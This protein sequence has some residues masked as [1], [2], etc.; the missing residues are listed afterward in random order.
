MA[1]TFLNLFWIKSQT[2]PVAVGDLNIFISADTQCLRLSFDVGSSSLT[3]EDTEG[4][5]VSDMPWR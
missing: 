5:K 1:E 2:V 4:R 3:G